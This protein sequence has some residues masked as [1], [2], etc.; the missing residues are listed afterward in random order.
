MGNRRVEQVKGVFDL[1]K[2]LAF[3]DAADVEK[4][5]VAVLDDAK[6]QV[7]AAQ[8]RRLL[9]QQAAPA[10]PRPIIDVSGEIKRE[11]PPR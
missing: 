4:K 3:G 7:V 11:T 5:A 2:T 8:K 1:V 10:G 9:N 6:E